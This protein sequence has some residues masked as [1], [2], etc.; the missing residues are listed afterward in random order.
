[1]IVILLKSY[2][3]IAPEMPDPTWGHSDSEVPDNA[4]CM[5]TDDPP[6]MPSEMPEPTWGHADTE[7]PDNAPCMWTDDPPMMTFNEYH[8]DDAMHSDEE[9]AQADEWLGLDYEPE[10]RYLHDMFLP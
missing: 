4:P 6:M 10:E 3:A 5:W 2:D 8:N 9:P 1:M 7:V